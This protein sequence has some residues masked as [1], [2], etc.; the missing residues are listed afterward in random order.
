MFTN[1]AA[2]TLGV[3]LLCGSVSYTLDG[4]AVTLD[5]TSDGGG[6]FQGL[7]EI[8][9]DSGSHT[10]AAPVT[11]SKNGLLNVATGANLQLTSNLTTNNV[12]LTKLGGGTA[13]VTN[14]RTGTAGL[15]VDNGT[16]KVAPDASAAGV[17]KVKALAIGPNAR[18]DLTNNKL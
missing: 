11:M 3:L 15:A 9:V 18:L 12:S 14:V 16:L 1:D 5:V 6:L 7:P 13:T 17:S 8:A 2:R 4:A 10:V